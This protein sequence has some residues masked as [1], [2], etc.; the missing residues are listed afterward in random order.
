MKILAVS[1]VVV[2]R[3]YSPQIR[4]LYRD[5]DLVVGCGDLPYYYL[6]YIVSAL[7]VPVYY[8]RGNHSHVVE[9]NESGP[10]TDPP[11]A[12]DL[13]CQAVNHGGL[14]LAGVEGS[15]RYREGPFQ[16]SQNEMWWNVFRLL[17]SLL[18][19]RLLYGRY[20]DVFVTHAPPWSI[21][22]QEDLPHQ[23]IKAFLW[24]LRVFR[25]AYHLHGHI[26]IYHPGTIT[27]TWY[28]RSQVINV[29]SQRELDIR[30]PGQ[31]RT[32]GS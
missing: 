20:L 24:F 29:F 8:V 2:D 11:G 26:H 9:Y 30:L 15:L 27:H 3:I 25:P 28:H 10:C 18:H 21:H 32:D 23:G 17:P 6:E 12:V 16:Y 22:D 19:N 13:H 5:V 4:T 7:N 14:L 31:P 1:D